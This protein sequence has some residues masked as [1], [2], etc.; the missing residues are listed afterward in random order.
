MKFK[1]SLVTAILIA[2]SSFATISSANAETATGEFEIGLE[3][4][5]VCNLTAGASSNIDLGD[6]NDGSIKTGTNSI[7]VACSN[8][9]PYK[10]GFI[11]RNDSGAGGVGVLK[12]TKNSGAISIIYKLT[13]DAAGDIPWGNTANTNTVNAT[14]AGFLAAVSY[15]VYATTTGSTDVVPDTYSDMVDVTVTY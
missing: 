12:G 6:V 7:S 11:A 8:G 3:V 9:T 4:Q 13:Q 10:I 15:P 1:K 14:G 5:S 2:I